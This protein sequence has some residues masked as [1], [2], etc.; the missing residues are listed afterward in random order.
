VLPAETAAL[1]LA[2]WSSSLLLLLSVCQLPPLDSKLKGKREGETR[3][4]TP[5]AVAFSSTVSV[6][7]LSDTIPASTQTL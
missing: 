6:P 1:P 2:I 5:L 7:H 3:Q 4:F